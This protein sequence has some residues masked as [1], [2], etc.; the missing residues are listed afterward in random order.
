MEK[1]PGWRADPR[2]DQH[3]EVRETPRDGVA[4]R[5]A[6]ERQRGNQMVKD[7]ETDETW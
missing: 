7:R 1:Q 4:G 6:R 2:Q 5:D 3:G